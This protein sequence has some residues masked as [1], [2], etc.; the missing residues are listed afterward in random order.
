MKKLYDLDPYEVS[1]V[2]EGANRK[3]FLIFKSRKGKQM[4]ANQEIRNLIESVDPKKMKKVEKVLKSLHSMKHDEEA[5]KSKHEQH[6]KEFKKSFEHEDHD[7]VHKESED[8]LSERAQ[9]ALKAVARILAPFK[10]EIHDGH[11]DAVQHE[12]GIK[13][14]PHHTEAATDEVGEHEVG[15]EV[16]Y[17]QEVK[18]EHHVEALKA[19]KEAY[20]NHIEKLGYQKYP[21]KQMEQK[22]TEKSKEEEKEEE[23]VD[24]SA[25]SK[26]ALDLTAFPKEQRAQLEMIFKANNDLQ[27]Q[28]KEL[29]QKQAKLE[30]DL[31]ARI[32]A[33]KEREYVAKAA[34]FRHV[35][36]PLAE[37]IETL[38]D[39]AKL[40]EKSYERVCKQFEAINEQ[41]SKGG[42][43]S[44]IG[45]RQSSG[46]GNDAEAKLERLVDSVVQK[47]EGKH[48]RDEIYAEVLQTKEG[49]RLYAEMK[50][51]RPGG[52]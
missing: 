52:I 1:L 31:S 47:S 20:K 10:D 42:L 18:E 8:P 15:K 50:S 49:K 39:A 28:N 26:S 9:A 34:E 12:V 7:E 27:K 2:D 29:V 41:I 25:V 13:D 32:E 38:K 14:S 44:E 17:P 35:G 21:A 24:K 11:L 6:E 19:A 37:V 22:C 4:A 43:F 40:G 33:E 45:S 46:G 30:K 36:L 51:K 3:K 48:S 5:A 16:A 23:S